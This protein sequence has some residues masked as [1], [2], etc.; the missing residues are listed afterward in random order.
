MNTF[1]AALA[2][3]LA[4]GPAFALAVGGGVML[5]AAD[6]LRAGAE[7]DLSAARALK[8][9][10]D[11]VRESALHFE[12]EEGGEPLFSLY[13]TEALRAYEFT[14]AELEGRI[15]DLAGPAARITA[16]EFASKSVR[17]YVD[18]RTQRGRIVYPKDH[19]EN[20]KFGAGLDDFPVTTGNGRVPRKI[21]TPKGHFDIE[22]SDNGS[23]RIYRMW[24]SQ[25]WDGAPM[26]N[27]M[28]F[29]RGAASHAATGGGLS[30]L[31]TTPQS[32]GCVRLPTEVSAAFRELALRHGP[33]NVGFFVYGVEIT[34]QPA[35][36]PL[37]RP[38]PAAPLSILP[39]AA[40]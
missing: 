25:L 10:E 13:D 39:P 17:L 11:D 36:P 37:P 18:V 1:P 23:P 14:K 6:A 3:L 22:R 26:P 27:A 8:A 35:R 2:L 30:Q 19:P 38:A 21:W 34:R 29:E 12:S 33:A 15:A 4:A 28:F 31:G 40:R 24:R 5:D 32:G 16:E 7:I 9:A 20:A